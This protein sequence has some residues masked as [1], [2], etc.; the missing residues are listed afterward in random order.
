MPFAS[1]KYL[2]SIEYYA[3]FFEVTTAQ[4]SHRCTN[5][6]FPRENF[7]DILNGNPDLYAPIWIATSV[8]TVLYFS[9]T[10]AGYL[11]AHVSHEPYSYQ[12]STLP[13]AATLIYGYTFCVPVICWGVLRWYKCEPSL[14][15]TICLYG[16]SK[17]YKP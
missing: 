12:F 17:A 5:A 9:S 3:Q 11:A 8:V 15:D 6:L 2:W 7:F 1:K 4:V 14:L 13:S 16:Y 10:I